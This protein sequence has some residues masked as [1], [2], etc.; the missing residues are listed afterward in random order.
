MCQ[1]TSLLT[2]HFDFAFF[3]ASRVISASYLIL[4]EKQQTK[5]IGRIH[6]FVS[7]FEALSQ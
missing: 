7:L 5:F 4:T 6:S 1:F 3:K 2:E